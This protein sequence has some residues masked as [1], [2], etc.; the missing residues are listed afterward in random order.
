MEH[1]FDD[2]FEDETKIAKTRED[3]ILIY[4][5]L[6]NNNSMVHFTVNG[7]SV[8]AVKIT[9]ENADKLI[10][11]KAKAMTKIA[12]IMTV[13][14]DLDDEILDEIL[15]VS[16][17]KKSTSKKSATEKAEIFDPFGEGDKNKHKKK[18]KLLGNSITPQQKEKILRAFVENAVCVPAVAREQGTTIEKFKFWGELNVSK[19]LFFDIYNSSWLFKD[20]MDAIYNLCSDQNYLVDAYIN[21]MVI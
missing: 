12:S 18:V 5:E 8:R 17:G 1:S 10:D 20:R 21:K 14:N 7:K 11:K 6:L 16:I 2:I 19:K 9:E 15:T 13:I 3:K 4:K